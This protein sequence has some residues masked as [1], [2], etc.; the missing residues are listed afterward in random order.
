M[1]KRIIIFLNLL[2]CT[3]L[4]VAGVGGW[5][6]YGLFPSLGMQTEENILSLPFVLMTDPALSYSLSYHV[7]QEQAEPES[8][9]PETTASS[10]EAPTTLPHDTQ[11]LPIQT[12]PPPVDVDESWFDDALFIGESR[13]ASLK[14]LQ[15]L[16]NADYF[17]S[18]NQT[19]YAIAKASLSD[20]HFSNMTLEGLLTSRTYGKIIL[21]FGINES[22][23]DVEMFITA[24]AELL[25]WIRE[26]QPEAKIILHSI[27][28][29]SQGYDGRSIFQPEK[30]DAR[31]QRI[32][33]LAQRDGYYFI[34]I[35]SWCTDGEG[36]L[37]R[38]YTQDG[39]HPTLYGCEQWAK[40]LLEQA[41]F[42]ENGL[43]ADENGG[44]LM[45]RPP[46]LYPNVP[47]RQIENRSWP[48]KGMC[49]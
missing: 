34:D 11:T 13:M 7:R 5:L 49:K 29:V 42:I 6:K 37:S 15:R 27:M 40:W 39:C 12:Q 48:S 31:S 9:A 43:V 2:L 25:R 47:V 45:M 28:P 26:L 24:Y 32:R 10:T 8:S 44:G 38:D 20:N 36:W 14:Q 22:A 35:R 41:Y 33:E 17:C 18:V 1:K 21:N 4:L 30:L 46:Q 19:V 23:G 3:S 16:G